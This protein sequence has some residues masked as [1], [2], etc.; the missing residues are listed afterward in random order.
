MAAYYGFPAI[1]VGLAAALIISAA[2]RRDW[3]GLLYATVFTGPAAVAWIAYVRYEATYDFGV[4]PIRIDLPFLW[5][6]LIAVSVPAVL[7]AV[8]RIIELVFGIG[9]F[10]FRISRSKTNGVEPLRSWQD[11]SQPHE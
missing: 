6:G 4:A 1:F 10:A 11:P 8:V 2:I 7:Y 3:R 9:F 5:T